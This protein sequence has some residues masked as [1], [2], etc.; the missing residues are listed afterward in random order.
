MEVTTVDFL[1]F[2]SLSLLTSEYTVTSRFRGVE[3]SAALT[4]LPR[5]IIQPLSLSTK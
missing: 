1:L 4:Y 5:H 2:L 3:A